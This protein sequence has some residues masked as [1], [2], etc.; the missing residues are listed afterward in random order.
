MEGEIFVLIIIFSSFIFAG[1]MNWMKVKGDAMKVK[2]VKL[3]DATKAEIED[4]RERVKVL[5]R[6][7]T[8]R[9]ERLKEEIDAL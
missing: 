6:I 5:E 4:L 9:R 7:V 3:D 1:I 2:R 8:D